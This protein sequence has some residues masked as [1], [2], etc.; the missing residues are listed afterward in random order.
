[1]LLSQRIPIQMR[2]DEEQSWAQKKG[3]GG[4]VQG[5]KTPT[6]AVVGHLSK[7]EGG[8]RFWEASWYDVPCKSPVQDLRP[9][10]TSLFPN[11]PIYSFFISFQKLEVK[12]LPSLGLG[13]GSCRYRELIQSDIDARSALSP[14]TVYYSF[15]DLVKHASYVA[16]NRVDLLAISTPSHAFLCCSK[17]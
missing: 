15:L 1:M 7:R 12:V 2:L 16:I 9:S 13:L 5:R 6:K 10:S 8:S 14:Y 3:G 4:R 11:S 17:S